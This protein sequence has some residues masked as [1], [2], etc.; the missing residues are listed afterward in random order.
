MKSDTL[1]LPKGLSAASPM[2][3]FATSCSISCL[4]ALVISAALISL[5]AVILTKAD[6]PH[7]LL[8]PIT[9]VLSAVATLISVY[10]GSL[11]QKT[12]QTLGMGVSSGALVFTVIFLISLIFGDGEVTGQTIIKLIAFLS[13][14]GIGSLAGS[15]RKHKAKLKL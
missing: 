3:Q 5:C 1:S 15:S 9:T 6:I 2:K 7:T 11:S 10:I 4:I 13:A 12:E 14:G 8:E